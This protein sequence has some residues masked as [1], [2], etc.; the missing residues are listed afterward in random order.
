M[1]ICEGK[2]QIKASEDFDDILL[3]LNV[4]AEIQPFLQDVGLALRRGLVLFTEDWRNCDKI[5]KKLLQLGAVSCKKIAKNRA[6]I[7]NHLFGVHVYSRI[8]KAE[9][10][11]EFLTREDFFPAIIAYGAIPDFLENQMEIIPLFDDLNTQMTDIFIELQFFRDFVHK[12]PDILQR[13]L[14]L[15]LTSEI[16]MQ[17]EEDSS[18]KF[19]LEATVAV[20]CG[21]YRSEH[22]EQE[23]E[24]RRV[25]LRKAISHFVNLSTEFQE[26]F[27]VLDV[28]KGAFE[29][30]LR[31]NVNIFI[32]RYDEIGD[33]A[34]RAY[35]K[36]EVLLYDSNF[37]YV[38]EK[39]LR[40]ACEPILAAIPFP[41]IKRKLYE[42]GVLHANSIANGNFTIK[43]LLTNSFGYT[44]RA[45]FLKIRRE[46]FV[47][48]G[49]I[50]L[51]EC[52]RT[53]TQREYELE[54]ND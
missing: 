10:I 29:N 45:R 26:E 49:G 34:M 33:E 51:E 21:I 20:F 5:E 15:F 50:G 8:D 52:Q 16:C 2:K 28:V 6:K 13:E 24:Q 9:T 44:F 11:Q 19:A 18:L 31:E 14:R 1:G 48:L 25:Q 7:P 4:M 3:L 27:E 32:C 22:T 54:R 35:E 37:Y 17:G 47:T 38:P 40:K 39:M 53:F 42:D 36:S 23:T 41:C 30:Y 12:N 43:K 46:F